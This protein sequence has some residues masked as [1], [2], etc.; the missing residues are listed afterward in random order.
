MIDRVEKELDLMLKQGIIE[1]SDSDYASPMVIEK[2]KN[3]EDLRMCRFF[4]S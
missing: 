3:T 2:K 4:S 1:R